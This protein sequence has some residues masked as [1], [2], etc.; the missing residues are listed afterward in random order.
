MFPCLCGG[1]AS[2]F[3]HFAWEQSVMLDASG[4]SVA[5][6]HFGFLFRAK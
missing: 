4:S 1:V 2:F 6:L 5:A 3:C